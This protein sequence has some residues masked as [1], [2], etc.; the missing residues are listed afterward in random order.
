MHLKL[1]FLP[2]KAVASR[3]TETFSFVWPTAAAIWNLRWQ[4]QGLV[5]ACPEISEKDL[6]G[7][8]VGGSGIHGVNLRGAC[9]DTTWAYQQEQFAKFLLFEL[10][11]L[12]ESW[13][14]LTTEQLSLPAASKKNLQ[15][16]THA[17]PAGNITGVGNVLNLIASNT[18]SALRS[19]FHQSLATNRKYSPNHLQELLVCY[20]YFKEVRN[21]LIH[22][23]GSA[24][25]KL[26]SA[27]RNYA[28]LTAASLGLSERP[29]FFPLSSSTPPKLSLRGVVG[30]G[31]VVLKLVCT[32]DTELAATGFAEK[33]FKRRWRI[34]N[35][36]GASLVA[37]T[38]VARRNRR[39][40][41]LTRK[42]GLPTPVMTP[43]FLAW[44]RTEGLIFY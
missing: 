3:I 30:F 16:P 35:G 25:T 32:I 1:F 41:V 8:F 11:A 20:R 22:G 7:R 44:L 21:S 14:E 2:S 29:E 37:A 39:I 6:F 38:D 42:L 19:S 9:I 23:S 24:L 33:D 31:E 5:S 12:Y 15:F 13:C 26:I 40:G 10:C 18:S 28:A 34:E 17:T 4:V 27:E 36:G 43:A